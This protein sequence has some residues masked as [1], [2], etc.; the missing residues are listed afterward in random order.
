MRRVN[1]PGVEVKLDNDL[2]HK[3]GLGGRQC[4][5]GPTSTRTEKRDGSLALDGR[6]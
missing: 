2:K 4:A 1:G 6:L 3:E 5:S